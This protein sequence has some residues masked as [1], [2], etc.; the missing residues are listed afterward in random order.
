MD[1]IERKLFH[2]LGDEKEIPNKVRTVI[3]ERIKDTKIKK[4]KYSFIKVTLTTCAC[5]IIAI[6]IVYAGDKTYNL[7][8]KEQKTE[9]EKVAE[10]FENEDIIGKKE[11]EGIKE[12]AEKEKQYSTSSL[13]DGYILEYS[14]ILWM[15]NQSI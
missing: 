15:L 11:P 5:L 2:D 10:V 1:D 14:K 9:P 4:K 13:I 6:G 3:E 8:W 7:I 12:E